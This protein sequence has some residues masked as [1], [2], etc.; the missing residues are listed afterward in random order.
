MGSITQNGIDH[1]NGFISC[2]DTNLLHYERA[3]MKKIALCCAAG[4]S[5][6]MLVKKMRDSAKKRGVDIF[7]DAFPVSILIWLFKIMT[8]FY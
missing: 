7:I 3:Y 5:T 4:M 2:Y 6:S 1:A 8:V